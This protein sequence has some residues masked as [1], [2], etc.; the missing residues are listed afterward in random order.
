[1]EQRTGEVIIQA[2]NIC[3]LYGINRAEAIKMMKEGSNKDEVQKK[4]GVTVAL[5]DVNLNIRR[6]EIFV[7]I[8]LSGSGKSTMVRCFNRLNRPTSGHILLDG[9]DIAAMNK[10]EILEL[11]RK[12]IS[13]IFQSFGLMSH[14]DVM[15][16]VAYGLE[17][18]GVPREEREQKAQEVISMVGL[19]GWERQS[20]DSLSGGMRQRVGIARA[21]ASDPEVLLM[22]EPFS[23]LDPLVRRDMQF[24]LLSI[25]RKLEKTVIFI[26]HD[27]D[28]AFKLGDTVAIMRDGK[29]VQIDTPERM[30]ANP[31][32]D[33]VRRFIDSAD[34][35][36]VLSV[37]NI[38]ITPSCLVKTGDGV[39][40]AISE[41]RKNATSSAFVVDDRLHLKG[42]LSIQTAIQM[43][44]DK[45]TI[46]DGMETQL[47]T[48]TSDAM[49]S[50]IMGMAAETPYP[51][52]V[53]DEKNRLTGIV[54]KSS[55]LSSLI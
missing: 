15:G 40:H 5:W 34:R 54:T 49:V 17:V 13:M 20:C 27:I 50:D 25:Q 3:K 47:A 9:D 41:M 37:K 16:N 31:A 52:A 4:T 1:M 36:K 18:R 53:V 51:I 6:G 32:D 7:I 55:V 45:K 46:T 19:E 2:K 43:L 22:D 38:M 14:R 12:R 35:S 10:K 23:A 42:I 48:T 44:H 28:E 30:S 24:E 26:T 33:Y 39:D 21:L 11:R 29:V 8:G